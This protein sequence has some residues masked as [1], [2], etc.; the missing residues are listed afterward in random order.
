MMTTLLLAL[1]LQGMTAAE[2]AAQRITS[3]ADHQWIQCRARALD[4]LIVSPRPDE[5]V[6]AAAFAACTVEE[7][8]VH[9]ALIAQFGQALGDQGITVFKRYSR[10]AMMDRVRELRGR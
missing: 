9:A 4:T 6:V 10:G 1:A 7:E 2:E 5:E 8:A 3:A